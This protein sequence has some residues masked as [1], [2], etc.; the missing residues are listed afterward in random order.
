MQK[1]IRKTREKRRCTALRVD[2]EWGRGRIRT[3]RKYFFM[4]CTYVTRNKM[5][6]GGGGERECGERGR[7]E[8]EIQLFCNQ[9]HSFLITT[10]DSPPSFLRRQFWIPSG[11]PDLVPEGLMPKYKCHGPAHLTCVLCTRLTHHK[12]CIENATERYL[13]FY[14]SL[15]SLLGL[16]LIVL[17]ASFQE[18]F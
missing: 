10:G 11:I 12:V 4:F 3:K 2:S 9:S 14:P 8:R 5:M 17:K 18:K 1:T 16:T 7:R 6:G 15:S 13:Y